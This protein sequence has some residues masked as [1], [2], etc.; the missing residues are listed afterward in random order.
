MLGL[1]VYAREL[2]LYCNKFVSVADSTWNYAVKDAAK[3]NVDKMLRQEEEN[4]VEPRLSVLKITI[5]N[6]Q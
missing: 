1:G 6:F 2:R 4:I 5:E 3:P